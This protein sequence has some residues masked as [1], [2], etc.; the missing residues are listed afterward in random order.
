MRRDDAVEGERLLSPSFLSLATMEFL[1]R[2][3]VSGAKSLLVLIV[4]DRVLVGDVSR[5]V[6]ATVF[7]ETSAAM[8]GPVSSTGLASQL[9]GYANALIYLAIPI[10]GLI[11]DLIGSRRAM[12]AAGGVGMLLGLTLMLGEPTFLIGLVPFAIGAGVLKGNLSA[13]LGALF[14]D[15]AQ[16]RRGYAVYLG[17]LNAGVICGPLVCG[18]L[19]AFAG[20]DYAIRAAAAAVVLGLAIYAVTD[21]ATPAV[22]PARST[23]S[24]PGPARSTA[25]L[26]VALAAVYLCYS[27]YDQLGN[28]F[29]VWARMRADR[30]VFGWTMPVAWFLSLDG[31][32]TLALIAVSEFASRALERRGIRIGAVPAIRL[33]AEGQTSTTAPSMRIR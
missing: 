4:L 12:V 6:G 26:V 15:E 16:R 20:E 33:S 17:F 13:Q 21:R 31:V 19:A 1:E 30:H 9:Y 2:F 27:A 5:V 11:G 3:A 7:S 29:L 23:T 25:L 28:I 14:Q 32:F 22:A 8:F 18:A 24:S 10:G